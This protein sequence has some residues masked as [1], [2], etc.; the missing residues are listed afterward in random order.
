[1]PIEYLHKC[2][3]K[4]RIGVEEMPPFS[5]NPKPEMQYNFGINE[6]IDLQFDG[7]LNAKVRLLA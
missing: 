6:I 7:S 3:K 2:L 1:M 4:E 5:L